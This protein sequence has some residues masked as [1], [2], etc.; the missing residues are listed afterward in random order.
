MPVNEQINVLDD[1]LCDLTVEE[2]YCD[3]DI[4]LDDDWEPIDWFSD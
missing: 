3:Q 1:F 4:V 2:V